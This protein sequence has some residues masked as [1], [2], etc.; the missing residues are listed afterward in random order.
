MFFTSRMLEQLQ[1]AFGEGAEASIILYPGGFDIEVD[2]GP[3]SKVTKSVHC[4][5]YRNAKP[6]SEE[7]MQVA[8]RRVTRTL[9]DTR[10]RF[11]LMKLERTRS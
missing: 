11:D 7:Q 3:F 1:D 8:W 2:Y 5:E 9:L 10:R 4:K 6:V